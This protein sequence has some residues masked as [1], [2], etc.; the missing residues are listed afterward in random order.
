MIHLTSEGHS[1][2]TRHS[3]CKSPALL[4]MDSSVKDIAREPGPKHPQS[5]WFVLGTGLGY[6]GMVG[7]SGMVY[8][9]L[10]YHNSPKIPEWIVLV[11]YNDSA[12]YMHLMI[13][14]LW[15]LEACIHVHSSLM[16]E[17]IQEK[18]IENTHP[19]RETKHLPWTPGEV[20]PFPAPIWKMDRTFLKG[21]LLAQGLL[22]SKDQGKP[23]NL[24]RSLANLH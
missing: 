22:D 5:Y 14:S 21:A 20:S 8:N 9:I 17:L 23:W 6:V 1:H 4:Q 3:F 12:S 2:R 15:S 24:L 18:H 10:V 13:S 11:F 19:W 16:V 7:W